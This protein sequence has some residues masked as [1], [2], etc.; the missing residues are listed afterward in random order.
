MDYLKHYKLLIR[1]AKRRHKLN[2]L[3]CKDIYTEEH[4]IIPKA[5]LVKR[6]PRYKNNRNKSCWINKS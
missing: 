3:W 5:I 1:N 6:K 4:H 2:P